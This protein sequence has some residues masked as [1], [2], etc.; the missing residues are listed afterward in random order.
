MQAKT[1]LTDNFNPN[2][3]PDGSAAARTS[4]QGTDKSDKL[5]G[6]YGHDT[7]SG[8]AGDDTI[9][10]QA[11]SDTIYG[12]DGNDNLTGNF[13]DDTP[14]WRCWQRHPH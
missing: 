6:G 8:L 10:G 4:H 13:G 7:I 9:D 14:L 12:G 2:F 1:L 3:P 5:V 11:G